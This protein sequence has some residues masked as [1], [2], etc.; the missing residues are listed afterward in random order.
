MRRDLST[1]RR[2]CAAAEVRR[3]I[4]LSSEW[5]RVVFYS[6]GAS[7]TKYLRPIIDQLVSN[8]GIQV[9]Y[10]TSDKQDPILVGG[11]G[12]IAAFYVGS[13]IIRTWL[14]Q[15]LRADVMVMTMP[16]LQTFHLKR[17]SICPVHY[18]YVHHSLVSTHRIY[19]MGA[20]DHFDSVLCAGPHH[21]REIR[22]WERLNGL[23]E[24]RLF[25]HGYA[26]LDWLSAAIGNNPAPPGRS[27]SGHTELSILLA[28]SWG[29]HGLLERGAG[30]IVDVLLRAGYRVF[31]RPH[32][33]TTR[34]NGKAVDTLAATFREHNRFRVETDT[35]T[36]SALLN[37][38]IMISDWSGV[39]MEFAFG[40]HRPVLFIDGFSKVN[41]V[42]WTEVGI[43]PLEEFY[44]SAVGA[45]V[46][47]DRLDEIPRIIESLWQNRVAYA[48]R[49]RTLAAQCV[50]NIGSSAKVGAGII[51]QLIH[52]RTGECG[53]LG[54][55]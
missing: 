46:S 22:A 8:E 50:Y 7:Y 45:V 30:S 48:A 24:K 51:A 40:L 35:S 29:Q 44:R 1:S 31:V 23:P 36:M 54:A 53:H 19:R 5:R 37:S 41:N 25:E 17:S 11:H 33:M 9:A 34:V 14:F 21:Q 47:H 2:L 27:A 49:A 4:R 18:A 16:D 39:A 42:R 15:T 55:A 20:F 32:P 52:E 6:E 13:G 28:P 38:D 3:F 43:L 26:P 12:R 10:L